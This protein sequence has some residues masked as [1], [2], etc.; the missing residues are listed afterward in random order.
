M[1]NRLAG[2]GVEREVGHAVVD[3]GE[4]R[5]IDRRAGSLRDLFDRFTRNEI[6]AVAIF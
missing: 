2:N 4:I 1:G 5:T 3:V 6:A